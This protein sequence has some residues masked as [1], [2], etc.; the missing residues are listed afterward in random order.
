MAR[1]GRAIAWTPGLDAAITDMRAAGFGWDAIARR[2]GLSWRPVKDRGLA[3]GLPDRDAGHGTNNA[4][5]KLL[6][7]RDRAGW[8]PLE[9][10]HEIAIEELARRPDWW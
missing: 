10:G 3:I 5:P 6:S 7:A 9:S 1:H 4:A 8:Q 2:L